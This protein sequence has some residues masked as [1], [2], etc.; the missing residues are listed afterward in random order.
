MSREEYDPSEDPYVNYLNFIRETGERSKTDI[1]DLSTLIDI[2][3]TARDHDDIG[4]RIEVLLYG[5]EHYP[6]SPDLLSRRAFLYSELSE[7]ATAALVNHSIENPSV[8]DML[9]RLKTGSSELKKVKNQ[10][11]RI[12]QW[13]E[14]LEDEEAIRLVEIATELGQYAWLRKNKEA[15]MNK[16]V[17]PSA[18]LYE[19]ATKAQES[20]YSEDA[21]AYSEELT[22]IEPFNV[23]FWQRLTL[24]YLLLRKLDKAQKAI[25]TALDIEPKDLMSQKIAGRTNL[26]DEK[27][28]EPKK[29][30]GYYEKSLKAGE[31]NEE[32]LPVVIQALTDNGDV[33][34]IVKWIKTLWSHGLHTQDLA[35][36]ML[37]VKP[38]EGKKMLRDFFEENPTDFFQ[39]S[40]WLHNMTQE[41]GPK[42]ETAAQVLKVYNQVNPLGPLTKEAFEIYYH[43]GHYDEIIAAFTDTGDDDNPMPSIDPS[44]EFMLPV[45]MSFARLGKSDIAQGIAVSMANR[46]KKVRQGLP[47]ERLAELFTA[48]TT[49]VGPWVDGYLKALNAIAK[50]IKEGKH[51]DDYDPILQVEDHSQDELPAPK[52]KAQ[53]SKNK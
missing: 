39:I 16:C 37:I 40:L 8:L 43:T 44:P 4:T 29:V 53:T 15:I 9:F 5:A 19:L 38:S 21:M 34:T 36:T 49:G 30:L 3:D 10:L 47:A 32:D 26:L 12:L 24:D 46:L 41:A 22:Q 25:E 48:H 45:I 33:A 52:N 13:E 11:N 31:I 2:Y 27:N 20:D 17:N 1:Y 50:G 35:S 7:D 6:D 18:F 28:Y 51:P 14:E 23:N 42:F